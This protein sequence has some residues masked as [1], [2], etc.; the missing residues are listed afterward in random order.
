MTKTISILI[1]MAIMLTAGVNTEMIAEAKPTQII[2]ASVKAKPSPHKNK[3]KKK[4]HKHYMPKG[5]MKKWFNSK[6]ALKKYASSVMEKYNRQYENGEISWDE[7]V[8]RCP[9]GYEAWSCPCGKW[10]GNFKYHKVKYIDINYCIKYA[11]FYAKQI[12]LGYDSTAKDCWDNPI[13]VTTTNKKYVER[14]IKA[15]LDH[16]KNVEHF[17]GICVWANTDGGDKYLLYIGYC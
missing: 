5:N 9:Y 2:T 7:Y 1:A 6:K 10:T 11:K 3:K 4:K 17:E 15:R 8:R 12:G 14:D 13:T 16:Y